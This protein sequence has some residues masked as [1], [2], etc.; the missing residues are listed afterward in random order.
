ML[1]AE[2]GLWVVAREREALCRQGSGTRGRGTQSINRDVLYFKVL[3][4]GSFVTEDG[5]VK[6]RGGDNRE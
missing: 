6:S 1:V 5:E 2:S 3:S 4:I